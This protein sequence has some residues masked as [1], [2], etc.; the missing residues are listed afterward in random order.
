MPHGASFPV[1]VAVAG[2][3][4]IGAVVVLGAFAPEDWALFRRALPSR[5]A[6]VRK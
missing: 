3:V 1:T 4:Y 2:V 6:L 5:L